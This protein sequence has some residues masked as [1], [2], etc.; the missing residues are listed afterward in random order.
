MRIL[1]LKDPHIVEIGGRRGRAWTGRNENGKIC[2]ITFLEGPTPGTLEI[3]ID[4]LEF[5]V[6]EVTET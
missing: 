4:D 1:A 2:R 5:P 3:Q 6:V